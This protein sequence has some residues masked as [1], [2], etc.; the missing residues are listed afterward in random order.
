MNNFAI[1]ALTT[2]TTRYGGFHADEVR[3][4]LPQTE[5]VKTKNMEIGRVL[6][7]LIDTCRRERN[8]QMDWVQYSSGIRIQ[9]QDSFTM[10]NLCAHCDTP[11]NAGAFVIEHT[12]DD[13]RTKRVSAAILAAHAL[14]TH[15]SEVYVNTSRLL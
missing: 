15:G 2:A 8:T 9:V 1:N 14:E 12:N 7:G 5:E 3:D 4:F 10:N 11:E 13:G 6:R